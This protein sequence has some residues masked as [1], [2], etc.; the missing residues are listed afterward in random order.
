MLCEVILHNNGLDLLKF[1]LYTE[2]KKF[3]NVYKLVL[4]KVWAIIRVL[5]WNIFK[6]REL[7]NKHCLAFVGES[8]PEYES[9]SAWNF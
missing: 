6:V 9:Y 8:P 2:I 5:Y 4:K 3:V 7:D 1:M